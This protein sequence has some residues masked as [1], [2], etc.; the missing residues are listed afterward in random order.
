MEVYL[1][2]SA[3]TKITDG[4]RDI[5]LKVMSEDYGNPSSLHDGCK[6]RKTYDRIGTKDSGLFKGESE[7]DC[8]YLR[9]HRGQ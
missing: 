4:V 8:I 1:D 9:R 5:M 2:N 7:G 6:C 3:T